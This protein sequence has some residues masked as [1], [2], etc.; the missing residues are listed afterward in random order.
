MIGTN[1][2]I[3]GFKNYIELLTEK[4]FWVAINNS[5]LYALIAI[6]MDLLLPYLAAYAVTK[7][8]SSWHGIYKTLIFLPSVLPLAVSSVIFLW[9]YNPVLGPLTSFLKHIGYK[10][11]P[12]FLTDHNLV[13]YSLSVIVGWKLFGYNFIVL[14]ASLLNVPSDQI[15]AAKIDGATSWQIF[16]HIILPQTS[17][18]IFY[19]FFMTI[20]LNIQYIFVPIQILTNGGPDYAST[21][22]VYLIYQYGFSF[23]QSGKAA[24]CSIVTLIIFII[25]LFILFK[26]LDKKVYYES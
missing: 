8:E 20:V 11:I 14:L 21:N 26:V 18:T 9:L 17:S 22:L 23:F 10:V 1:I 3:V 24:A 6:I 2:E 13:I 4:N 15:N 25:F 7:V 19:V 5:L 12:G 16:L